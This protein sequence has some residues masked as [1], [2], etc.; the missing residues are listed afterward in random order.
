M[1]H[2]LCKLSLLGLATLLGVIATPATTL[3]RISLEGLTMR[4]DAIVQVECLSNESRWERGEIWTFTYFEVHETLKGVVPRLLTVRLP[5]GK[6]G[7]LISSIE[8]VPR[9][10]PAEETILFLKRATDGAF[11][12]LSW[13][14]GT[15]RLQRELHTGRRFVL[16][17]SAALPVFDK[18]TRQFRSEGVRRLPLAIFKER[19]ARLILEASRK[20]QP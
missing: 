19:I 18:T 7:H 1:R 4:A 10:S 14:Q 17:D 12:V 9:F 11:T 16:Q 6:V 15:F 20:E 13:A 3:E 5:G 2:V 8:A